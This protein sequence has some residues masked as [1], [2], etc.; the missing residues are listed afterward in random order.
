MVSNSFV[1]NPDPKA[2]GP[3]DCSG[4]GL[5][6]GEIYGVL[7]VWAFSCELPVSL[8]RK[9]LRVPS[10]QISESAGDA[11]HIIMPNTRSGHGNMAV[12]RKSGI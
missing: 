8:D 3:L 6:L 10:P 7:L 4:L 11:E 5:G 2:L 12:L 9:P 1:L